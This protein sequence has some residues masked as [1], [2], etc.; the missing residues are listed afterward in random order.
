MHVAGCGQLAGFLAVQGQL[1]GVD[2]RQPRVAAQVRQRQ[3][4]RSLAGGEQAQCRRREVQ[5]LLEVLAGGRR[6][7][8][9]QVVEQQGQR[10]A[11]AFQAVLDLAPQALGVRRRPVVRRQAER[12]VQVDEQAE[13]LV[14]GGGQAQPGAAAGQGAG[15]LPEQGALAIAQRG[16]QQGEAA[17]LGR[18]GQP[19]QQARTG[20]GLRRLG[21][22]TQLVGLERG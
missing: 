19:L 16:L 3:P 11:G 5:Q 2:Q 18:A 17:G 1:V 9:L 14:L 8:Q 4:R 15:E 10:F 6:A 12:R 22:R 20:E 13:R 21:G 7:E